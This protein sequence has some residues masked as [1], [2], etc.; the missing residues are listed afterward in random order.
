VV[1]LV[2][3]REGCLPGRAFPGCCFLVVA[4]VF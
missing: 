4:K 2:L 3:R 1:F